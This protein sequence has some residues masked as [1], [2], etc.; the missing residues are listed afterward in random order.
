[1]ANSLQTSHSNVFYWEN[2]RYFYS[3]FT[4]RCFNKP[5][6]HGLVPNKRQA[7]TWINDGPRSQTHRK[8]PGLI[9]LTTA[10]R[11][12]STYSR[13]IIRILTAPTQ[14]ETKINVA[15]V[16]SPIC[17][18]S[19]KFSSH[20]SVILTTSCADSVEMSSRWLYF[21]FRCFGALCL[22]SQELFLNQCFKSLPTLYSFINWGFHA[23]VRVPNGHTSNIDHQ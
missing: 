15:Q 10:L 2:G 8:S 12:F 16:Q 4:E 5:N 13:H 22:Y 18:I 23:T 17:R 21:C 1:M 14:T 19:T 7:I 11:L 6:G 3:N 20:I 9:N